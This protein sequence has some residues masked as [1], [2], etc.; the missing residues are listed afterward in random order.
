[1]LR[2]IRKKGKKNRCFLKGRRLERARARAGI[3]AVCLPAGLGLAGQ[4]YAGGGSPHEREVPPELLAERFAGRAAD[5]ETL[6]GMLSGLGKSESYRI[7]V[8]AP[9]GH[10]RKHK[11][12]AC[13]EHKNSGMTALEFTEQE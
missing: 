12:Y 5:G 6:A 4:L 1:M 7:R 10:I 11:L 9:K 3:W 8:T 13:R 2:T